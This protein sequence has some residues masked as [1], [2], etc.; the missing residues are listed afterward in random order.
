MTIAN[1]SLSVW[2][3]RFVA[4]GMLFCLPGCADSCSIVN[5]KFGVF[6]RKTILWGNS[7]AGQGFSQP[8]YL[9]FGPDGKLYVT[10]YESTLWVLTLDNENDVAAVEK[11][12]PLGDD[13]MLTGFA[14]DPDAPA[15]S[16]VIYVVSCTSPIYKTADFTG[17]ISRLSGAGFSQ[18]DNLVM[19]LPRSYEN[20]MTFACEFGPDGRLYI[21]QGGNTN[22]GLPKSGAFGNR[23]ESALSAAILV[24]DVKHPDFSGINDVQ[25]FAPGLRNPYGLCWHSNGNMYVEDQGGNKTFG[26]RPDA[27]C[28]GAIDVNDNFPDELNLVRSGYYYGHPNPARGQC[29]WEADLLDGTPYAA[30]LATYAVGSV[31]TGLAE[32]K[33]AANGGA[34]LGALLLP[35]F[36]DGK[37]YYTILQADGL[38]VTDVGVFAQ[39]YN[40]PIDL[41]VGPGGAI[42]IAEAGGSLEYGG[43]GPSKITVLAPSEPAP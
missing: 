40:N 20:H 34:L 1:R 29:T 35:G 11:Y 9:K 42:F 27:D 24:A 13:Q 5:T 43:T 36:L 25:V 8:A 12:Q 16:P 19:G 26:G 32:Y 6:E 10:T 22:H 31:V 17:R 33:S 39:T 14:F 28:T 4:G 30:P 41:T 21:C 23:E 3:L 2:L 7:G 15:N 18:V 37:I 38:G